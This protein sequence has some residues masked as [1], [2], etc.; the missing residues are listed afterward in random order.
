MP[1]SLRRK[2]VVFAAALLV[3][4]SAFGAFEAY[5][6]VPG[7]R[8]DSANAMR[9]GV[10]GWMEIQSWSFGASNPAV[11]GP[12]K[13]LGAGRV[14]IDTSSPKLMQL[15]ATGRHFPKLELDIQGRTYVLDNVSVV[16][17]VQPLKMVG[18]ASDGKAVR[19]DTHEVER[20]EL[21]YAKIE[22]SGNPS[23]GAVRDD[24]QKQR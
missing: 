1:R 24:W 22:Y 7:V 10:Q 4:G 13:T 12:G 2:G 17:V 21:T 15:C 16:S 5:L 20:V 11:M 19:H 8:G 18:R 23:K 3:A 9:P 6:K 14:T